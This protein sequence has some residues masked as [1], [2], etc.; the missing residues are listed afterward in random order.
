MGE[1][2]GSG[3]QSRCNV[4]FSQRSCSTRT[5]LRLTTSAGNK[6]LQGL[7][8]ITRNTPGPPAS[9]HT[10]A[11]SSTASLPR[12]LQRGMP[13]AFSVL[14]TQPHS[15]GRWSRR[16][17]CQHSTRPHHVTRVVNDR[18]SHGATDQRL[19][20]I[21]RVA[22]SR[23]LGTGDLSNPVCPPLRNRISLEVRFLEATGE[24][25]ARNGQLL[26]LTRN[27]RKEDGIILDGRMMEWQRP[28]QNKNEKKGPRVVCGPGHTDE[29]KPQVEGM[30]QS[31]GC[32]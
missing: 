26:G 4:F 13:P 23:S 1:W 30:R 11:W 22:E 20:L 31:K 21:E 27:R 17:F 2:L 19:R 16:L 9:S 3:V 6:H 29:S 10:R 8:S 5:R 12:P 32:A 18:G 15:E 28:C 14:S 24:A 25:S 7:Q